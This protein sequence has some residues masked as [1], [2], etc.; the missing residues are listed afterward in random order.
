[1]SHDM[2]I[3]EFAALT[4][5]YANS[6]QIPTVEFDRGL[7]TP[8]ECRQII[9]AMRTGGMEY[10]RVGN[11]N[12]F[13]TNFNYRVV[14]T[15]DVPRDEFPWLYER[16][17]EYV[18]KVNRE[19]FGVELWGLMDE[20]IFMEYEQGKDGMP[21]GFFTWHRDTGASYTAHRK[22]SLVIGLSSADA[23]DG[24]E[25]Q[26][27]DGGEKTVGKLHYGDVITIPSYVQHRVT[28]VTEGIRNSLVVFV[29][30]PRWK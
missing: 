20:I 22:L 4:V 25:F 2:K 6:T 15:K 16:V 5:D 1:M 28:P 3:S 24:G 30:G 14:K 23:Y 7:L 10:G 17:R 12:R 19:K 27:F 26:V 9:D 18:K 13:S 8:E 11:N 21:D 29:M